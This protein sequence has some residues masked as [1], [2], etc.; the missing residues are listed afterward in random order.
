M[1]P[2]KAIVVERQMEPL[3]VADDVEADAQAVAWN[4]L[5]G[6]AVARQRAAVGEFAE[7]RVADHD[8]RAGP[9]RCAVADV[10]LRAVVPG[11]ARHLLADP[12]AADRIGHAP[13]PRRAVVVRAREPGP[14]AALLGTGVHERPGA[15][16]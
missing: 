5:H 8:R 13:A 14:V 2:R 11:A 12:A 9:E 3:A 6:S 1:L 4:H 10:L 15:Q 7:D 16:R